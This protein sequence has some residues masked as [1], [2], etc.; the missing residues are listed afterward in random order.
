MSDSRTGRTLVDSHGSRASPPSAHAGAVLR[1]PAA[2]VCPKLLS[3]H[4]K[5]DVTAA[6]GILL[7]ETS[8]L[9][10]LSS[11]HRSVRLFCAFQVRQKS[12]LGKFKSPF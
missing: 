6:E 2:K 4:H 1:L 11:H 5:R 12:V 8:Q 10:Q 9:S 3:V 7:S